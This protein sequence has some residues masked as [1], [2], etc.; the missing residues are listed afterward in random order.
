MLGGGGYSVDL[1]SLVL[2]F[3]GGEGI[4]SIMEFRG[5]GDFGFAQPVGDYVM[6]ADGLKTRP[7]GSIATLI[8]SVAPGGAFFARLVCKKF[9]PGGSRPWI[10]RI[11]AHLA[12]ALPLSS[13]VV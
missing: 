8:K 5:V 7:V 12:L 13:W 3:G 11:A 4:G 6:G 10:K 9:Y 2:E 1:G